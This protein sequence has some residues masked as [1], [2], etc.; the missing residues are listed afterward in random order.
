VQIRIHPDPVSLISKLLALNRQSFHQVDA[1]ILIA[2]DLVIGTAPADKYITRAEIADLCAATE[3]RVI[4]MVIEAAL[5]EEDFESAYAYV[6]ARLLPAAEDRGQTHATSHSKV[7]AKDTLWRTSLLAGRL[8][9]PRGSGVLKQ[10][11]K[12][13]ELLAISIRFCPKETLPEVLGQWRRCEEEMEVLYEAEQRAEE[14]HAGKLGSQPMSA[15]QRRASAAG[16]ARSEEAPQ[17]LFEVARGAAKVFSSTTAGLAKG[18]S[19]PGSDDGNEHQ[20]ERKRDVV[21]GMVTRGEFCTAEL[22]GELV[23]TYGRAGWGIGMDAW[24]TAELAGGEV[25][26]GGRV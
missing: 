26:R 23:L 17:S 4:G 2:K 5:G 12:K 10:L 16:I 6:T 1:L 15:E 25:G 20:R 21:S 11:E 7:A 14:E 13:M 9:P 24:C 19:T 18:K 3:A 22:W 8:A